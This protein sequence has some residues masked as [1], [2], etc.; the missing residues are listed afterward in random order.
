MIEAIGKGLELLLSWIGLFL[1]NLLVAPSDGV[2]TMYIL[3]PLVGVAAAFSVVKFGIYI[4]R[5]FSFGF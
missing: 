1:E 2:T 5:T 3:L 4:V